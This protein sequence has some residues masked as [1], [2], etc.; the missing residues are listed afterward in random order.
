MTHTTGT[1]AD[2]SPALFWRHWRPDAPG[3]EVRARIVLVHGIH[4][5]SGRYA[6]VASRLMLKGIEV[7][8]LDLRGHGQ[9]EGGRGEIDAFE[10]YRTDLDRL[11]GVVS[12]RGLDVP[13]FL[14]GHSMGGLVAASWWASRD[15]SAFAGLILSSPALALPPVNAV[16]SVAAPFVAKRFPRMRVTKLDRSALSRDPQVGERYAADPL[17]TNAGVQARTGYELLHAAKQLAATPEAF[18]APLYAFHGTDDTITL[19]SGS[20]RLVEACPAS[21]ATLRL[22]RGLRH[23]TMNEPERDEVIDAVADWVLARV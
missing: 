8:A 11:M 14:M 4:E 22:W 7:F 21:D 10:E 17:V 5:H 1:L 12:A 2:A 18:T 3:S 19:P 6:Y 23:E 9:S 13:A 16:L 15:H 20:S